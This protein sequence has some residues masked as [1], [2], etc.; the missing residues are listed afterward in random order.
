[1]TDRCSTLPVRSTVIPAP[2]ATHVPVPR[3]TEMA[4]EEAFRRLREA[5]LTVAI[6]EP[7]TFSSAIQPGPLMQEPGA[8]SFLEPGATVTL[9]KLVGPQGRLVPQR[10]DEATVPSLVGKRADVAIRLLERECLLWGG[11]FQ[12]LP[13]SEAPSL[14]SAYRV[15]SQK[16]PPGSAYRQLDRQG[17]RLTIQ[18]VGFTARP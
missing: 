4:I 8:G 14:F 3:V 12:A 1:M 5:G 18:P 9:S 10:D 17:D 7:F 6:S 11:R 15:V 13:P 2:V 16:P